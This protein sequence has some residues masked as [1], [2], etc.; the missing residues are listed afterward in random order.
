MYYS[1]ASS[2]RNANNKKYKNIYIEHITY[3]QTAYAAY[4]APSY[5]TLD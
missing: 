3:T 2:K 4:T 5:I 1:N